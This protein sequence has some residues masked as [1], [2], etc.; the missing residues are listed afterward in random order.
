M[1]GSGSINEAEFL[2]EQNFTQ[3]IVAA[4]AASN[5]FTNGGNASYVQYATDLVSSGTFS[6]AEA[7]NDFVDNDV[8]AR[9]GTNTA[10]GI[11]E[12]IALL[13][14]SNTTASFMIVITD[15]G[16]NTGGPPEVSADQARAEG[17]TVLAVGVG[18]FFLTRSI[19]GNTINTVARGRPAAVTARRVT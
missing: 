9:G 3:E 6:S 2:Q 8:Q 14:V 11:D 17:I 7:F 16:S 13:G 15:G 19:C 5:L 1:D 10:S 12:G 18:E 4:F